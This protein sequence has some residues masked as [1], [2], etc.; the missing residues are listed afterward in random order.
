VTTISCGVRYGEGGLGGHLAELIEEH[1]RAGTLLRYFCTGIKPGDENVGVA[2]RSWLAPL[3]CRYTPARFHRG[4][5][6][7]VTFDWFDRVVAAW[8]QDT[9]GVHVGFSGLSYHTFRRARQRGTDRLELVS[10]TAHLSAVRRLHQRAN[11]AYPL[12]HDWL[13]PALLAKGLREYELADRVHVGS[14]YVRQSF[15]EA[16]FREG[17]MVR[18]RLSATPRF[19]SPGTRQSDGVFRLVYV[20]ALSVTKG[21]PLLL[22]AFARANLGAATLTLVGQTG[23]RGMRRFVEGRLATDP[24]IL[25][26]PGD[27]L[28]HL[29][30]AD[31]Y[32]HPSYQDGF[33]YAVAE[34]LG[35][36]VPVIVTEDTGAKELVRPSVNG[37]V[38]PTGDLDALV[39]ALE[40]AHRH[41]LCMPTNLEP[42]A[43]P[44]RLAEE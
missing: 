23:S 38:V 3:V 28:P 15:L 36:S 24:R 8:Y 19:C 17:Q 25:V 34:A 2:A 11:R 1:R 30:A 35:V 44:M 40:N 32:V 20:G 22:D 13:H 9:P 18:V 37:W 4:L 43:E 10:P 6:Q 26:R 27:P 12:E 7:F 14:E 16:G 31:I 29:R 42:P 21:V 39:A 5:A 33:G 41:P